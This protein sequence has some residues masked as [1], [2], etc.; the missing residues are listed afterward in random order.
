MKAPLSRSI[1]QFD[2]NVSIEFDRAIFSVKSSYAL[3]ARNLNERESNLMRFNTVRNKPFNSYLKNIHN[4]V[5]FLCRFRDI[6][7]G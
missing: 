3:V 1:W 6:G 5:S 7:S 2:E 4:D